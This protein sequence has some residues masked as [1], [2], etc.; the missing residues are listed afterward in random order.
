MFTDKR[1]DQIFGNLSELNIKQ[2]TYIKTSNNI[3]VIRK[4]VLTFQRCT[5]YPIRLSRN[6]FSKIFYSLK[7]SEL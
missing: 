3:A 1:K 2:Y 5:V 6:I 4:T 7:I